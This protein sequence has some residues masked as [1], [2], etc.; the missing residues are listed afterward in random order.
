MMMPV[1]RMNDVGK[2][3][4]NHEQFRFTVNWSSVP[5]IFEKVEFTD[6]SIFDSTMDDYEVRVTAW[7]KFILC[8]FKCGT[9]SEVLAGTNS[10]NRVNGSGQNLDRGMLE[11]T[12][13]EVNVIH[14]TDQSISRRSK[15]GGAI[16]SADDLIVM[17]SASDIGQLPYKHTLEANGVV[18][19]HVNEPLHESFRTKVKEKKGAI[20]E[21]ILIECV[22]FVLNEYLVESVENQASVLEDSRFIPW[23][24]YFESKGVQPLSESKHDTILEVREWCQNALESVTDS[25]KSNQAC[26][27]DSWFMP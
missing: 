14:S 17:K 6:K 24:D 18:E 12:K 7:N 9:V 26:K 5:A 2:Q 27:N 10:I 21:F 23:L 15:R 20:Q 8:E 3:E 19:I 1:R 11:N 13:F 25:R 4:L 16:P 22:R